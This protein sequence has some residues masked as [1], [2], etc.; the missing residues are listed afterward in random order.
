MS[1]QTASNYADGIFSVKTIAQS[2]GLVLMPTEM[3]DNSGCESGS[4]Q[5][6]QGPTSIHRNR[7][8]RTLI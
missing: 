3:F 4:G 7:L 2:S 1:E 6:Q 5:I 8:A